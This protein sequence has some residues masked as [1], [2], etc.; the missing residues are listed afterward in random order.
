MPFNPT[1]TTFAAL[2]TAGAALA[3]TINY[4]WPPGST[5]LG[6]SPTLSTDNVIAGLSLLQRAVQVR[7]HYNDAFIQ[8]QLANYNNTNLTNS[9]NAATTAFNANLT[10]FWAETDRAVRGGEKE[11]QNIGYTATTFFPGTAT[12]PTNDIPALVNRGTVVIFAAKQFPSMDDI[13]IAL[14]NDISVLQN[15]HAPTLTLVSVPATPEDPT[16]MVDELNRFNAYLT[17]YP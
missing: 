7:N 11:L 13:R 17:D 9:Y 14:S 8:I 2:E 6:P 16:A 1:P 4:S 3:A 15:M 10:T 5:P 12:T